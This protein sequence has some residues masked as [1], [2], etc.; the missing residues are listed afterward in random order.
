MTASDASGARGGSGRSGRNVRELV[1]SQRTISGRQRAF[2]GHSRPAR[3]ARRRGRGLAQHVRGCGAP[4]P[5]TGRTDR[6]GSASSPSC[7]GGGGGVRGLLARPPRPSTPRARRP[8]AAAAR[9]TRTARGAPRARGRTRRRSD[10]ARRT[11]PRRALAHDLGVREAHAPRPRAQ[12]L[13][14]AAGRLDQDHPRLREHGG[15]HEA[16]EARRPAPRSAISRRGAELGDLEAGERVRDVHVARPRSGAWT[17][18]GRLRRRE[19]LEQDGRAARLRRS[20][21]PLDARAARRCGLRGG[22]AFHVK[23]CR[24]RGP[25][26]DTADASTRAAVVSRQPAAR[27]PGGD[28]ARC[29]RSTSPRRRGP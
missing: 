27:R 24:G 8:R 29:P 2:R 3:E 17:E 14:L 23:R 25:A 15:E 10:R 7:R 5:R 12:E 21:R 9:R 4:S 19:Q 20:G 11:T 6:T 28:R 22:P 26:G 18:V 16:R 1:R 13:A